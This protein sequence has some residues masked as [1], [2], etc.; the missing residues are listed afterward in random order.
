M[1]E[2]L[3]RCTRLTLGEEVTTLEIRTDGEWREFKRWRCHPR[4]DWLEKAYR[5]ALVALQ[6]LSSPG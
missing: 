5:N 3:K 2:V 6:Q 4:R 1:D